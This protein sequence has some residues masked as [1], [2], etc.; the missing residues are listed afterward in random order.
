M[1]KPA[2]TPK[3]DAAAMIAAMPDDASIEEIFYRLYVLE[4]IRA[5]TAELEAGEGIPHEEV[6]AE[7]AKWLAG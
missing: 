5:G 4:H 3:P 2:R 7:F 1:N 6:R